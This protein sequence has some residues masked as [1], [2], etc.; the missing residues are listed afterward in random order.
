MNENFPKIEYQKRLVALI[1]VMGFTQL[2]N[3]NISLLQKFY[4]D[5]HE[6]LVGKAQIY[7]LDG[8]TDDFKKVFVSDSIVLSVKLQ[9]DFLKNLEI[10]SRFFSAI[11]LLQYV[12]AIKSKIWTRGAVSVG[13]LFIDEKNNVLVGPAFVQAFELEKKANY[14]RVIIDPK[15]CSFFDLTPH[16][17]VEKI[18]L[19]KD[20][21]KLIPPNG[22]ARPFLDSFRHQAI[23]IDWFCHAFDRVEDLDLFFNDIKN[24]SSLNQD[25]FQKSQLLLEYLRESLALQYNKYS[26]SGA[27]PPERTK[28]IGKR[29]LNFGYWY[30]EK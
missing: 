25:L 7:E 19:E 22:P 27:N 13:D 15:I 23:Q 4:T 26:E 30:E 24:R 28:N 3:S 8:K 21:A 14:P 9:E 29:L 12:L 17:F 2:L 18:N 10:A 20:T 16:S 6:F 1:D 11:A 5:T